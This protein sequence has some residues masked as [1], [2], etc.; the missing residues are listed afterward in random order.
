VPELEASVEPTAPS[1]SR[2]EPGQEHA[3]TTLCR[4]EG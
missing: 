4:V 1:Q 2:E 3:E